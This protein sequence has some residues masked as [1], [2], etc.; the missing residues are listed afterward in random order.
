MFKFNFRRTISH[1]FNIRFTTEAQLFIK[2]KRLFASVVILNLQS[3]LVTFAYRIHN[4]ARFDAIT[5]LINFATVIIGDSLYQFARRSVAR[6]NDYSISGNQPLTFFFRSNYNAVI[7]N[8]FNA[9]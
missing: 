1:A 4:V 3:N 7:S 2:L 5:D 9:D 8:L 6:G